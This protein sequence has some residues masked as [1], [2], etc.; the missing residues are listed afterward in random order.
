VKERL[1]DAVGGLDDAM[2]KLYEMISE[3]REEQNG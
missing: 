3:N 1:I 2:E